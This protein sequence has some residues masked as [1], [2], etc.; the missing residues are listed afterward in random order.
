MWKSTV[1]IHHRKRKIMVMNSN[2]SMIAENLVRGI[3]Y[4][5]IASE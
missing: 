4:K 1:A 3:P 2:N 5:K